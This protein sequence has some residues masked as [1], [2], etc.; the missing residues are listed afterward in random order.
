M[1]VRL[2]HFILQAVRDTARHLSRGRSWGGV[3]GGG[4]WHD[5][6]CILEGISGDGP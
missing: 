3:A 4:G 6:T 2:R 5:Q 1:D